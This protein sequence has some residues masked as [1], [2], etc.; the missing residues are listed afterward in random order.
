MTPVAL[1]AAALAASAPALLSTRPVAEAAPAVAAVTEP[2]PPAA[3]DGRFDG[4]VLPPTWQASSESFW[5]VGVAIEEYG[6]GS[7]SH[8]ELYGVTTMFRLR[9]WGPHALLML[10]PSGRSYEDTRFVGGL[11]LRG[12]LP[13]F[14]IELSYGVGMQIEA[15]LEDHFWL[16]SATPLELGAVLLSN[17]NSWEIELF[18]GARRAFAGELI[19]SFLLDPNGFDNEEAEAVLYRTRTL[20]PWSGFI[21]LQFG[22]RID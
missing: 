15:R 14:G 17:K 22:R 8:D 4:P 10:K 7:R 19:N 9:S 13:V 21:R 6:R 2:T 1:T 11:G 3:V 18:V 5:V 16:A 12:Y 20:E